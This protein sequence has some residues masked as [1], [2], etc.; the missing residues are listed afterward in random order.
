MKIRHHDI[1]RIILNSTPWFKK[2]HIFAKKGKKRIFK[3]K[4]VENPKKYEHISN[5]DKTYITLIQGKG[6]LFYKYIWIGSCV[7]WKNHLINFMHV[8]KK[9]FLFADE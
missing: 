6:I 1:D 7:L 3:G 4:R 8:L 5:S 9:I 2:F